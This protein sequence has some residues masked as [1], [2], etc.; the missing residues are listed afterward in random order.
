MIE[1]KRKATILTENVFLMDHKLTIIRLNKFTLSKI[2]LKNKEE[3]INEGT[4][5]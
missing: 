2:N 4:I 1:N 3:T 5:N